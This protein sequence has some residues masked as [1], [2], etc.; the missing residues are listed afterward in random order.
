MR[1]KYP[2]SLKKSINITFIETISV[3]SGFLDNCGTTEELFAV[4]LGLSR[5]T[6]WKRTCG[7]EAFDC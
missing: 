2:P 5:Y 1:E 3:V 6:N 7:W 4:I